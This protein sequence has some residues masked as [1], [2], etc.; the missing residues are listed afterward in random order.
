MVNRNIKIENRSLLFAV[1]LSCCIITLMIM[2][3]SVNLTY[4]K[5]W[6]FYSKISYLKG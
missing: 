2:K 4:A 6:K 3:H 5:V 1:K